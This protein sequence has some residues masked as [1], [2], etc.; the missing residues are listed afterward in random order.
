MV[1]VPYAP[2]MA[3]QSCLRWLFPPANVELPDPT[4]KN[5]VESDTTASYST[6]NTISPA[7][8]GLRAP[9]PKRRRTGHRATH[10]TGRGN[11]EQQPHLPGIHHAVLVTTAL[12]PHNNP[13]VLVGSEP[14]R[15]DQAPS[16]RTRSFQSINRHDGLTMPSRP[17][18]GLNAGAGAAGEL[19]QNTQGGVSAAPEETPSNV[20]AEVAGW[21]HAGGPS[22]A[23]VPT[24]GPPQRTSSNHGPPSNESGAEGVPGSFDG[25][26]HPR[27]ENQHC[28]NLPAFS[29]LCGLLPRRADNVAP[30]SQADPSVG[31]GVESVELPSTNGDADASGRLTLPGTGTP[32]DSEPGGGGDQADPP[33]HEQ[34]A[35]TG[36]TLGDLTTL[37]IREPSLV[38]A[39]IA[40]PPGCDVGGAQRHPSPQPPGDSPRG[41][42]S[43][44]AAPVPLN[45]PDV[46]VDP[47]SEA[48]SNQ[49][50][51]PSSPPANSN[52]QHRDGPTSS[53]P[54]KQPRAGAVAESALGQRNPGGV[55]AADPAEQL[56]DIEQLWPPNINLREE[57]MTGATATQSDQLDPDLSTGYGD[58]EYY[59]GVLDF[60]HDTYGFPEMMDDEWMGM[61]FNSP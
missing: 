53:H 13:T 4:C 41:D 16:P 42:I 48:G 43:A 47:E 45:S 55:S 26:G 38:G 49:A 7:Q 3:S 5:L 25:Q 58:P 39:L 51:P 34:D 11:H 14:A 20:L 6:V 19:C 59:Y 8:D 30:P 1:F 33:C 18:Q 24:L 2:S 29:P 17:T 44:A 37:A 36:A 31:P 56:D 23:A 27:D 50:G 22:A 10:A 54:T 28:T 46:A 35:A 52:P 21:G 12:P 15:T 9:D 57:E 32:P 60:F 40:G 61:Y